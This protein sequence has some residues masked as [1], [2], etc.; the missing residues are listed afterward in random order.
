ME[1]LNFGDA[2]SLLK[3]G[4]SVCRDGWN[5]KNMSIE[6]KITGW[7]P[8]GMRPDEEEEN[9]YKADM[10]KEGRM[11]P[12]LIMKTAQGNYVPWLASQTDILAEDWQ[13]VI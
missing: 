3:K 13:E 4:Y 7:N 9:G 5:G 12:F 6:L 11:L 2:L 1:A 8:M 10:Y